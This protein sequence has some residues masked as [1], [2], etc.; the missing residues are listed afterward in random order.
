MR[1]RIKVSR[2]K[3]RFKRRGGRSGVGEEIWRL[4]GDVRGEVEKG[5]VGRG[6]G[7][8]RR[9]CR[10]NVAPIEGRLLD[11]RQIRGRILEA[12]PVESEDG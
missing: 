11:G 1:R 12:E 8:H 2:P 5:K 10:G 4:T 7:L 9:G 6:S 3:R